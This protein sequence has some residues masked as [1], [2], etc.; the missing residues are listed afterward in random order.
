MLKIQ[1]A[2]SITYQAGDNSLYNLQIG[3]LGLGLSSTDQEVAD[4]LALVGNTLEF[5]IPDY[6][7]ADAEVGVPVGSEVLIVLPSMTTIN[8]SDPLVLDSDQ[9]TLAARLYGYIKS[10]EVS[11]PLDGEIL[12]DDD[13]DSDGQ[14]YTRW[15]RVSKVNSDS[16]DISDILKN[17]LIIDAEIRTQYIDA[18]TSVSQVYTITET[19]IE[20]ASYFHVPVISKSNTG[21][22]AEGSILRTSFIESRQQVI[23]PT[24][25][26]RVI[27]STSGL[28]G[29]L[30]IDGDFSA[31]YAD[32]T[33]ISLMD[34]LDVLLGIFTVDSIAVVGAGV[35]STTEFTVIATETIPVLTEKTT[36]APYQSIY[37][38]IDIDQG[39]KIFT[40]Q[41]DIAST[42]NALIGRSFEVALSTGNDGIYTIVSAT[43]LGDTTEITVTEAIPDTEINGVIAL[44]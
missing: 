18:F 20:E 30:V 25:E 39:S 29:S 9:T 42:I 32:T 34:S 22:I 7:D 19:P 5:F 3:T 36:I 24:Y 28:G 11:A 14:V 44:V 4:V 35:D 1:E 41:S 23:I 33:M 27:S 38:I 10:A 21:E 17:Y 13:S 12:W 16:A 31:R 40:V 43:D 2:Y 15:L 26:A 6:I 8:I 37:T